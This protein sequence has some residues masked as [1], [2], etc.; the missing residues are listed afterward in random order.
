MSIRLRL[1]IYAVDRSYGGKLGTDR[2]WYLTPSGQTAPCSLMVRS[3]SL[4][5]SLR[6]WFDDSWVSKIQCLRRHSHLERWSHGLDPTSVETCRFGF[7]RQIVESGKP[8][9][10]DPP[11]TKGE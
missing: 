7:R 4:L 2:S 3:G 8:N 1:D 6:G 10:R 5:S 11:N 9:A